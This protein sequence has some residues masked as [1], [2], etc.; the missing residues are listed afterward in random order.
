M[1]KV[2]KDKEN[3]NRLR[4]GVCAMDESNK[5]IDYP[6]TRLRRGIKAY[7][8]TCGGVQAKLDAGLKKAARGNQKHIQQGKDAIEEFDVASGK[9]VRKK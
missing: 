7:D 4:V 8:N 1:K 2:Q 6:G 9:H 3:L 5:S